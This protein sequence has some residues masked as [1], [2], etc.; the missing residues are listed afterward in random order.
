MPF[1]FRFIYSESGRN[2]AIWTDA[3]GWT[4][5][6]RDFMR[7][8]F[9]ICISLVGN[10]IACMVWR[11]ERVGAGMSSHDEEMGRLYLDWRV[12]GNE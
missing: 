6:R 5:L 7:G 10:C 3:I 9:C 12:V 2:W 8:W 11:L 1:I 4:R